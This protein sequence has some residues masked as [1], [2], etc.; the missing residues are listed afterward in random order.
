MAGTVIGTRDALQYLAEYLEPVKVFDR[1]VME[2]KLA[3]VA[4]LLLGDNDLVFDVN[5]DELQVGIQQILGHGHYGVSVTCAVYQEAD[6]RRG[7]CTVSI[8][9]VVPHAREE[10]F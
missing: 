10:E 3:A 1:L 9:G 4:E 8:N 6:S 5:H 7:E 2:F